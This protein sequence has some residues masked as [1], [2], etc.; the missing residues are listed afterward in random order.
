MNIT[1]SVQ[2]AVMV[3]TAFWTDPGT[4]LQR[5]FGQSLQTGWDRTS[6]ARRVESIDLHH[7][8][9]MF[10][11][12]PVRDAQGGTVPEIGYLPDFFGSLMEMQGRIFARLIGTSKE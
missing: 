5:K 10:A 2:I 6:F 3:R 4:S 7:L 12:H 9:A 8:A 1:G 11:H